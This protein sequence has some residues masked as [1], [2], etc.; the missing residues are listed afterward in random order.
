MPGITFNH[1]SPM[2]LRVYEVVRG[3]DFAAERAFP[4][5]FNF[6]LDDMLDEY[7][8]RRMAAAGGA[9]RL[10]VTAENVSV[11]HSLK[12]PDG[13]VANFFGVAKVDSYAMTVT[14]DLALD[15]LQNGA[16]RA[17]KFTVQRTINISEHTSVAEREKRQLEGIESLFADIDFQVVE[18]L[19]NKYGI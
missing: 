13:K 10:T 14:I 18:I 1:L 8:S 3:E 7:V 19:R 15:N 4:N 16:M 6:P 5:D 9:E 11:V 2:N 17:H 12:D